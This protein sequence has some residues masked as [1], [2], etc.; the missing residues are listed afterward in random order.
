[1]YRIVREVCPSLLNVSRLR[2]TM[3]R[4]T[5][6]KAT[7]VSAL[8]F[9]GLTLNGTCVNRREAILALSPDEHLLVT[10][11]A[12]WFAHDA[13]PQ[14]AMRYCRTL[15]PTSSSTSGGDDGAAATGKDP[16]GEILA[17]IGPDNSGKYMVASQVG[18]AGGATSGGQQRAGLI[19]RC[20][21]KRVSDTFGRRQ[22]FQRDVH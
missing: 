11:S 15:A 17:A 7:T 21:P 2:A 14:F 9:P 8:M 18:M 20:Y 6:S 13:V 16:A 3:H 5:D 12:D 4:L 19:F 1:M 10:H 22:D